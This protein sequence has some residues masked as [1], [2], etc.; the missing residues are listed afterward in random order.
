MVVL[1]SWMD[2][3]KT[4][5]DRKPVGANCTM[6]PDTTLKSL[7]DHGLVGGITV[8]HSLPLEWGSGFDCI[9]RGLM[10]RSIWVQVW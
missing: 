9:F 10:S 7:R 1:V 2:L 4:K 5:L 6:P 3:S 8:A